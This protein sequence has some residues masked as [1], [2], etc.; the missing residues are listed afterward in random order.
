M[1]DLL[2]VCFSYWGK[3]H[4]SVKKSLV[5]MFECVTDIHLKVKSAISIKKQ[6]NSV[7]TEMNP[8]IHECFTVP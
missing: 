3:N 8:P 5:L 2:D 1:N 6:L 7:I 4:F